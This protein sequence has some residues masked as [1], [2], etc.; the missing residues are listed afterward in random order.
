[1]QK[2]KIV[3][4]HY[5]HKLRYNPAKFQPNQIRTPKK[6]Q[7]KL[8]DTAVAFKYGQGHWKWY[9]QVKLNEKFQ[10]ANFDIYHIHGVW[11]NSNLEFSTIPDRWPTRTCSLPPLNTHQ[12]ILRMIILMCVSTIQCLNYRWQESKTS[13]LHFIFLTHLWPWNKNKVI[14]PRMTL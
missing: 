4:I 11:E 13:N 8:F 9:E 10:Y 14:K 6:F 5:L 7:L 1:M 12:I 3:I 2:W